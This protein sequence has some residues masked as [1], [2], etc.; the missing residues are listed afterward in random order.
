MRDGRRRLG[1]AYRSRMVIRH[2]H[3]IFPF[4]SDGTSTFV[5]PTSFTSTVV[6]RS[7][8]KSLPLKLMFPVRWNSYLAS[9]P[10]FTQNLTLPLAL[11][12]CGPWLLSPAPALPPRPPR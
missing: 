8:S 2:L 10:S 12:T 4:A 1:P 3:A 6:V 5:E 9:C 7:T 11:E